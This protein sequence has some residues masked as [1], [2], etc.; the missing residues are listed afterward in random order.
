MCTLCTAL[1]LIRPIYLILLTCHM[2]RASLYRPCLPLL[3][4]VWAIRL[5]ILQHVGDV[6]VRSITLHL[7]EAHGAHVDAG[8]TDNTG[9]LGVHE[10]S[11]ATLCLRAG[12]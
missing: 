7:A 12:H 8:G 4:V 2:S 5:I 3:T 6:L 9:D 11:V 10:G 1:V